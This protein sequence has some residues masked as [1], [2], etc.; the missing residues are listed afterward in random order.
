MSPFKAA[1]AA[2]LTDAT[3][4]TMLNSNLSESARRLVRL[5][6]E[7]QLLA[8]P[9]LAIA[10]G[11]VYVSGAETREEERHWER[12]MEELDFE[13]GPSAAGA[14]SLRSSWLILVGE[15]GRAHV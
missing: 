13:D 1:P 8:Y 15:I 7:E 5:Y 4:D 12:L 9:A 14:A 2:A 11:Y 3:V 6:T 10:A